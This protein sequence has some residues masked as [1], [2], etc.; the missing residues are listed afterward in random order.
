MPNLPFSDVATPPVASVGHLLRD[1]KQN[2]PREGGNA[3]V[4]SGQ[5]GIDCMATSRTILHGVR[6]RE[7]RTLS[8]TAALM[9]QLPDG[10]WQA[11]IS[12]AGCVRAGDRIRFGEPSE[13]TVC[14]LSILDADV[15][16]A[17][18]RNVLL[19]FAFCG[20]ALSD[21]LDRLGFCDQ[22][23]SGS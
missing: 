3:A 10:R 23:R 21:A 7:A 9:L 11:E 8:V 15:T 20:P 19:A 22:V 13:S 2:S 12:P 4:E 5:V 16:W 14:L 18:D 17:D 6:S 1:H